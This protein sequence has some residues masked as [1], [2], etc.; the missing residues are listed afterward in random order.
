MSHVFVFCSI[1]AIGG[2][3]MGLI[4]T[5]IGP[6]AV[7]MLIIL[8]PFVGVNKTIVAP[9]AVA[10]S[11]M[12]ILLATIVS[13]ILHFKNNKIDLNLFLSLLPGSLLGGVLGSGLIILIPT[14]LISLVFCI[15]LL[16]I[17]LKMCLNIN[18]KITSSLPN[19]KKIFLYSAGIGCVCNMLGVSDG[20]LM[21]PFLNRYNIPIQIAIGTAAAL[22]IP[23]SLIGLIV[24][25]IEGIASSY[26]P[27]YSLGYIYFP[28]LFFIGL[29]GC[30]F[31]VV[32][33]ILSKNIS[34]QIL[35]KIFGFIMIG[36]SIKMIFL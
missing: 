31:A 13:S 18:K 4:G 36:L 10:T 15:L 5:G 17:G 28:A 16:F 20:I 12:A 24:L 3:F 19:H 33:I 22:V 11:L 29:T 2:I 32:G 8:L 26:L 7:P 9:M 25:V 6:I 35:R 23:V 1:G 27:A 30:L 21:V 14:Y 34:E